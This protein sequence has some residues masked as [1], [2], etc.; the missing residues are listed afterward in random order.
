M[1][2]C[3]LFYRRQIF[4]FVW[5][6]D[7]I[8]QKWRKN[9]KNLKL[10]TN[11][12]LILKFFLLTHWSY[13]ISKSITLGQSPRSRVVLSEAKAC[14]NRSPWIWLHCVDFSKSWIWFHTA[15]FVAQLLACHFGWCALYFL[16]VFSAL[17]PRQN[18]MELS[19][20]HTMTQN[21]HNLIV[22]ANYESL[23]AHI[24][25]WWWCMLLC[26]C[27][28]TKR[29]SFHFCRAEFCFRSSCFAFAR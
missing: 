2:F 29:D 19:H 5:Q 11:F 7:V 14:S 16:V 17:P 18:G 6:N 27:S 24:C 21:V 25:F 23:F 4:V 15:N 26:C 9:W 12:V 13:L 1:Q 28:H 22:N 8:T 3:Y 10:K 20:T